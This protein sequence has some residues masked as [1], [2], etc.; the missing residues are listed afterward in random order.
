MIFGGG[1]VYYLF[2]ARRKDGTGSIFSAGV[3]DLSAKIGM[4]RSN[5]RLRGDNCNAWNGLEAFFLYWVVNEIQE[6]A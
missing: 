3:R 5:R 4:C 6:T 2:H 1:A